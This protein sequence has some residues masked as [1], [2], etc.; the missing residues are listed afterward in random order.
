MVTEKEECG[1]VDIALIE[2]S[3]GHGCLAQ[4]VWQHTGDGDRGGRHQFD[5][6]ASRASADTL[7]I[8]HAFSKTTT[9]GL[10]ISIIVRVGVLVTDVVPLQLLWNGR[11]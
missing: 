11:Y 2:P 4:R 8:L 1:V 9:M 7:G 6:L 5:L 10:D 3:F